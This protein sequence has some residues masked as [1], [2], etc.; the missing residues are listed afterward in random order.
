MMIAITGVKGFLGRRIAEAA[1][2]EGHRV[3]GIDIRK[4]P[5]VQDHEDYSE[6]SCDVLNPPPELNE[7]LNEAD[8]LI[9]AAARIKGGPA[10]VRRTNVEGTERLLDLAAAAEPLRFVF[11]SSMA[12][13][14]SRANAYGLSKL[15]G[16]T[17][18]MQRAE[19]FAILRPAMIY[20]R[21]DP[22]WT[23]DIRRKVQGSRPVIL[24]GGGRSKIQPLYVEDAAKAVLA[25]ATKK[26]ASCGTF[27]LGGPEPI[28]LM[29]FL[30]MAQR[31]L[32]GKARFLS[33]PLWPMKLL[34]MIFGGR[35]AAAAAF[36]GTDH[37]VEIGPAKEVLE[38]TPLPPSEGLP[39]A[40]S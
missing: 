28:E 12:A 3:K 13:F 11:I 30:R 10:E 25:A 36:A 2:E 38:F 15:K 23:A 17:L 26:E 29:N 32:K 21:D 7:V 31:I 27:D 39:L 14:E 8:A 19:D 37:L 1:L 34:G 9:H 5:A 33:V 20:G 6:L 4:G 16:E 40:L 22:L 24:L 18:V 35:L